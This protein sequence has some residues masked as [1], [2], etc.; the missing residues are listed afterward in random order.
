[1]L[2]SGKAGGNFPLPDQFPQH[3]VPERSAGAQ[4]STSGFE[5][6]LFQL[7]VTVA[8]R[9]ENLLRARAV[10]VT[11]FGIFGVQLLLPALDGQQQHDGG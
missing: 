11:V 3:A 10:V 4:R 5:R 7:R 2:G 1:V 6:L 9:I 8:E